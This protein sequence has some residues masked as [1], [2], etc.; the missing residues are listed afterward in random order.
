LF[1]SETTTGVESPLGALLLQA[2]GTSE[3]SEI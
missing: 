2:E 3:Q 1:T